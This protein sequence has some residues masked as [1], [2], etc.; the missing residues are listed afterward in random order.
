VVLKRVLTK[1]DFPKPDSPKG[2]QGVG[3]RCGV[4]KPFWWDAPT[5]ITVN[6]K[7]FLT[8]L[9]W[10]WFGRLAKP[11]YPMSFLRMMG[12][13]AWRLLEREGL[14]PFRAAEPFEF[15]ERSPAREEMYESVI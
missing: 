4:Q 6:W 7:P 15:G 5:T 9:R 13:M 2:D 3:E 10:T 8:L 14:E 12:V 11:T 1:V